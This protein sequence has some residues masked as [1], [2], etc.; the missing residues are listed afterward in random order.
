MQTIMLGVYTEVVLRPFRWADDGWEHAGRRN[1]T[2][3]C[4]KADQDAFGDVLPDMASGYMLF[5]KAL[6]C[7]PQVFLSAAP[8]WSS[9]SWLLQIGDPLQLAATCT[10]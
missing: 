10:T 5:L 9:N 1:M 2:R 7:L 8:S 3:G 6:G 4:L